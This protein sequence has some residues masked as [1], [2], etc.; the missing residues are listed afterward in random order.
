[1]IGV[2]DISIPE[3]L[4][5]LF[6][7]AS[8]WQIALLL[9]GGMVISAVAGLAA[10]RLPALVFDRTEG[11]A[12]DAFIVSAVL[13]LLALLLG[14]TFSLALSRYEDRREMVLQEANAIGTA[15]L[16]AQLIDEPQRARVSAILVEYA[17]NRLALAGRIDD[18]FEQRMAKNDQL[19]VEL[20]AHTA[21][22][23]ETSGANPVTSLF[24][25][26]V[27]EVIDLDAARKNAR[28]AK[29][30]S[31]VYAVLM[32]YMMATAAFLGYSLVGMST[33]IAA[34]GLF[35]LFSISML[36]IVD[37]DRP[38][39]GMLREQQKPMEDLLAFFASASPENLSAIAG[40]AR[41]PVR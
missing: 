5:D 7:H 27:N 34:V 4:I 17:D 1:M 35:L 40:E 36:L 20:W 39:V 6:E 13:G 19:L 9:F 10:R 29:V 14:F 21:R 28:A 2:D 3:P 38:L 22:T 16:R 24:I 8:L 30:P 23:P 32:I 18:R 37:I 26:S 25:A 11:E 31:A 41:A 12:N 33:R 15:Y